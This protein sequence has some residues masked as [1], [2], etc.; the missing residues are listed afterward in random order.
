MLRSKIHTQVQI[1][2]KQTQ[3]QTYTHQC[4]CTSE[5]LTRDT[6]PQYK[7]KQNKKKTNK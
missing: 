4:C 1:K 5:T 6:F 3:S 2:K 7:Q